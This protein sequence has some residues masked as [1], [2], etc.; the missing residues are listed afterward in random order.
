[1][2]VRAWLIQSI[3]GYLADLEPYL[4]QALAKHHIE[5]KEDFVLWLVRQELLSIYCLFEHRAF[6]ASTRYFKVYSDLQE[7]VPFNIQKCFTHYFRAPR[8]F[9]GGPVEV[10]LRSHHVVCVGYLTNLEKY[11]PKK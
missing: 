11:D 5:Q 3:A 6:L 9:D 4:T 2:H 8:L 7:N 10:N 1:M